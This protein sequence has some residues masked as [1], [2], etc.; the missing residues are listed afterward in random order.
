MG[1]R[2]LGLV[3]AAVGVL[4]AVALA[5][6]GAAQGSAA[7]VPLCTASAV[8]ASFGGQGATQSLLGTVTV[9][10]HGRAACRL[11]GRPAIA[12]R[13]GSRHELLRE[14]AMDT[15][16]MWPGQRFSATIALASGRSA[17]VLFQWFNWCNPQ[18][19]APPTSTAAGGRRPSQVLVTVAPGSGA[20]IASVPQLRTM[21]L[22]VCGDP[23]AP[24]EINVSLWMAGR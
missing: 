14:R 11:S 6:A 10:N 4:A 21:Y 7:T 1:T 3:R 16:R 22:P 19:K 8:S 2:S 20:L 12:M 5:G 23:G 18:A 9:T 24:S 17:S 13:G 15:A